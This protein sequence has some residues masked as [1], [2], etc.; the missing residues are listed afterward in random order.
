[1]AQKSWFPVSVG[2]GLRRSKPWWLPMIGWH[3]LMAKG[4]GKR[5]E[6]SEGLYLGCGL[7]YSCRKRQA[8]WASWSRCLIKNMRWCVIARGESWWARVHCHFSVTHLV[9]LFCVK[10]PFISLFV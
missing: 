1:V 5:A 10:N 9:I 6:Q 8:G 4:V 3:L 2:F 7:R